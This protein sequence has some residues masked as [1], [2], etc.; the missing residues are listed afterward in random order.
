M[1]YSKLMPRWNLHLLKLWHA[2]RG[3]GF[4]IGIR[5]VDEFLAKAQISS[6]QN[7]TETA[8]VIA[9]V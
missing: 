1:S 5:L 7:F 2:T 3:R 4:N 9:K 6:C 8:E